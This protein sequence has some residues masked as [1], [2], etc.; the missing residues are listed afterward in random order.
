MFPP[1]FP[2]PKDNP[3]SDLLQKLLYCQQCG[4]VLLN[5]IC[6]NCSVQMNPSAILSL[7][8]WFRKEVIQPL[9]MRQWTKDTIKK[10]FLKVLDQF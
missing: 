1:N 9:F 2:Y 8:E 6:P 3:P 10:S 4:Q 5:N 7:E